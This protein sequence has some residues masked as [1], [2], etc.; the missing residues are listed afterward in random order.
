MNDHIVEYFI[1]ECLNLGVLNIVDCRKEQPYLY[2]SKKLGPGIVNIKELVGTVWM[3]KASSYLGKII[4]DKIVFDFIA[5]NATGGIVPSYVAW[6]YIIS[7]KISDILYVYIRDS[8]KEY[9]NREQVSGAKF[10]NKGNKGIVIDEL[11]NYGSN[12][13]ASCKLLREMG[14]EV[15]HVACLMQYENK[16]ANEK[17]KENGIEVIS[18]FTLSELLDVA[19]RIGKFNKFLIDEYREF[20]EDPEKWQ[21]KY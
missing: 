16:I 4:Y 14:F 19:E 15:N 2:S 21:T 11:I 12:S 10:L 1:E 20:L 6:E 13:L 9:G 18:I 5:G 7:H 8:K 17:F 3:R